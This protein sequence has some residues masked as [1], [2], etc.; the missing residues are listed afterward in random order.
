MDVPP[1]RYTLLGDF[2]STE[3]KRKVIVTN[4]G[5]KVSWV[6]PSSIQ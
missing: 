4:H 5:T 2:A 1:G 3:V 6:V